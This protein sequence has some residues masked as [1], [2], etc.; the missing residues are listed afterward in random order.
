MRITVVFLLL[1]LIVCISE[2]TC[3]SQNSDA[4]ANSHLFKGPQATA[5]LM[6]ASPRVDGYDVSGPQE[7][8]AFDG[9]VAQ[10]VHKDHYT[11]AAPGRRLMTVKERVERDIYSSKKRGALLESR[12]WRSLADRSAGRSFKSIVSLS[13]DQAAYMMTISLGTPAQDF[14]AIADTGSALTWL[15][16]APCS[17]NNCVPQNSSLFEP[18][19]SSSF[20]ELSC[21]DVAC[22]KFSAQNPRRTPSCKMTSTPASTCN[23][24][25]GYLD[26]TNTTGNL[27]TDVIHLQ[28][29]NGKVTDIPSFVFGCSHTSTVAVG[30]GLVGLG[31]GGVSF[32]SQLG[33]KFGDIF[34]YCL[35]NVDEA[36]AT[37]PLIFGKAALSNSTGLQFTPI[38]SVGESPYFY[39]DL[40]GI[41]VGGQQLD[42]PSSVF[43]TEGSYFDSGT[44]FT[45][46]PSQALDALGSYL[47]ANLSFQSV[48]SPYADL[49]YCW[50]AQGIFDAELLGKIPTIT[51][52]FNNANYDLSFENAFISDGSTAC[53][54][55]IDGGPTRADGGIRTIIGNFQQR[56]KHIVYDRANQRLG[57]VTRDCGAAV[58]G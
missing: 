48:K 23:Y 10:L 37:S 2:I 27:S 39:V 50:Q 41:S 9:I 11:R 19:Q 6:L 12:R 8:D 26:G 58:S 43:S 49:K 25:Y 42:I 47:S 55:I 34:S 7:E 14:V 33:S 15:Q 17:A 1:T 40:Q 22:E 28:K 45:L 54:S 18:R 53:L 38:L 4:P 51:F 29:V 32:P 52:K 35:V 5:R 24:F 44:T 57:F 21:S 46:L 20:A 16:C 30:V 3:V 13:S 31:Q 36:E 56:N